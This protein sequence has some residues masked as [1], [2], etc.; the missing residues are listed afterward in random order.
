MIGEMEEDFD[1]LEMMVQ[2]KEEYYVDVYRK[3]LLKA[4][5]V[6]FCRSSPK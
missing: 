5:S 6:I 3:I 2:E 4:K 1:F